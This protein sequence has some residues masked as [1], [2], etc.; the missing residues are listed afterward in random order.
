MKSANPLNAPLIPL[1]CS[2]TFCRCVCAQWTPAAA[3]ADSFIVLLF[4][5][6]LKS[7]K[8]NGRLFNWNVSAP[9]SPAANQTYC[10]MWPTGG[11]ASGFKTAAPTG[12]GPDTSPDLTQDQQQ[13]ANQQTVGTFFSTSLLF[14]LVSVTVQFLLLFLIFWQVCSVFVVLPSWLS[15]RWFC[16]VR[17]FPL[18][19][20][21]TRTRTRTSTWSCVTTGCCNELAVSDSCHRWEPITNQNTPFLWN[22]ACQLFGLFNLKLSPKKSPMIWVK[23][24]LQPLKLLTN[25]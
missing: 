6:H 19:S 11:G 24:R 7:I 21:E 2:R 1:W 18:S 4:R 20:T 25:C 3:S 13:I 12:P 14:F 10:I 16:A 9:S 8:T 5:L 23:V 22:E 17:A 15:P